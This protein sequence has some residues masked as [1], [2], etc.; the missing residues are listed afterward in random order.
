MDTNITVNSP[1]SVK[2]WATGLAVDYAKNLYFKKFIGTAETSVIQEKVDLNSSEGD[3]IKFDLSMRLRERATYGD[4]TLQGKEEQLKFLQDTVKIDQMRKAASGGGRMTRQR[5]LHDLRMIAKN[6]TAEYCAEWADEGLIIYLSGDAGIQGMNQDSI[7]G[8]TEFAGNPIEA[9]DAA[10]MAY[11]GVAVSKA[12]IAAT[13]KMS[14]GV[15]ERVS[16]RAMMLNARDPNVVA[17]RPVKVDGADHFVMLMN[18]DQNYDLRTS[19]AP[20]DWNEIQKVAGARGK[21][22]NIFSGNKG[23]INNV[24]L[25]EH[26]NV[27]RFSD[28]GAGSNVA[29]ARALFMGRQAGTIAYGGGNGARMTWVEELTDYKSKVGIAAGM[30]CGFKKTRYKSQGGAGSDF[31]VIAVDTAAKA[32]N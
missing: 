23:M 1:Q 8:T 17:M 24:V 14:V 27:R 28:Y 19:T 21:E 16:N 13:D 31:G 7:F 26:T 15:I 6:R 20:N 18:P 22:N 3:E 4:N 10:H 25:Q 32:P 29:A 9:P 11:G 5:T 30:I 12:T 2:R